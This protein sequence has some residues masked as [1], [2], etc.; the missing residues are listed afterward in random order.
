MISR[1]FP[2]DRHLQRAVAALIAFVIFALVAGGLD[3]WEEVRQGELGRDAEQLGQVVWQYGL[4][5]NE[6]AAAVKRMGENP[7][8]KELLA[9]LDPVSGHAAAA[10]PDKYTGKPP[11]EMQ[12]D[13]G[14]K[15]PSLEMVRDYESFRLRRL[16][17]GESA[18]AWESMAS[19][20]ALFEHGDW[21]RV[22][23]LQLYPWRKEG[24]RV[25][26]NRLLAAFPQSSIATRAAG[27]LPEAAV[28]RGRDWDDDFGRDTH[29][30]T[31]AAPIG[32]LLL[33]SA[34]RLIT[35]LA[36]S[37]RA[38]GVAAALAL[39][40]YCLSVT[41]WVFLDARRRDEN[42]FAWGLLALLTN[43]VGVALYLI[44][45]R[46]WMQCT[47]CGGEVE[48]KFHSCPWCGHTLVT[49]CA[50]CSLPLR[51]GWTHCAGCGTSAT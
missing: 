23:L 19:F 38:V 21:V 28:Q 13:S 44:A 42:P 11:Q 1:L 3:A 37:I 25:R 40:V 24:L 31:S 2:T 43:L 26:R 35:P 47:S 7:R 46:Q 16:A 50:Q 8:P 32:Y 5:S 17:R 30:V 12:L 29:V 41:W 9:V 34:P 20:G 10:W 45:R 14:V 49:V 36:V 48:K 27:A 15:L 4:Q 18:G 39:I 33:V 51:S 6:T 22:R